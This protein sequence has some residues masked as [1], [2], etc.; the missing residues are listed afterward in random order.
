MSGKSKIYC[1][2][3]QCRSGKKNDQSLTF[4]QFPKAGR[5]RV[6]LEHKIRKY[7]LVDARK[8]WEQKLKMEKPASN[9][10]KVCSQHF[11][12]DDY[13]PRDVTRQ[14]K[15]KTL[16]KTAVPSLKLPDDQVLKKPRILRNNTNEKCS[17]NQELLKKTTFQR[18]TDVLT[19][20]LDD[21]ST[22]TNEVEARFD[23]EIIESNNGNP[24]IVPNQSDLCNEICSLEKAVK[25][26]EGMVVESLMITDS[27][28]KKKLT[29]LRFENSSLKKERAMLQAEIALLE[30]QDIT[31][32]IPQTIIYNPRNTPTILLVTDDS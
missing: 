23:R 5:Y 26:V 20:T 9:Y 1:C 12:E 22:M 29:S 3:P 8:A 28:L 11:T 6:V 21:F 7:E 15:R 10:I 17:A 19:S 2:V 32:Q 13:I 14:I 24:E 27:D 25:N 4:H 18:I 16:K 30:N 31:S